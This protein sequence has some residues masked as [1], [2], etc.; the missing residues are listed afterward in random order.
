MGYKENAKIILTI[1]HLG[2]KF[3]TDL[4]P[5]EDILYNNGLD[6]REEIRSLYNRTM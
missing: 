6:I 2:L 1:E 5:G 3:S 4:F